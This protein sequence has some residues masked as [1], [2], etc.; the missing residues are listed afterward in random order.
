MH[1]L[2]MTVLFKWHSFYIVS[3]TIF[4]YRDVQERLIWLRVEPMGFC[5]HFHKVQGI[6]QLTE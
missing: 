5:E 6:S 2:R 4:V 3:G 1:E